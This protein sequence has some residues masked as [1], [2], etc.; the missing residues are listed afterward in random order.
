MNHQTNS[1]GTNRDN[2]RN[3]PSTIIA[4]LTVCLL[5]ISACTPVLP[6]SE[7]E[8]QEF[9]GTIED[10]PDNGTVTTPTDSVRPATHQDSIRLG[11]IKPDA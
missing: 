3:F 11:I 4:I 1:Y 8:E 10:W 2:K 9:H 7:E 6:I 5:S